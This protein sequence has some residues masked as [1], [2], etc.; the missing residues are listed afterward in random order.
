MKP[1]TKSLTGRASKLKTTKKA[2][3]F[4]LIELITVIVIVGVLATAISTFIKFGTQAY[5]QT[6]D[7]DQLVL[8]A[9]FAIERLNS[10]V[11]NALPNSLRL[12]NT[13]Q[14]VEF[15]P[16]L[17]STIYT[18]I[19][20]AP[21]SAS[22]TISVI[23]FSQ[24]F[25]NN[26]QAIVYPL[27]PDDVY[28]NTSSNVKK[29]AIDSINITGEEWLITLENKVLFAQDSPTQRIYFINGSVKYCLQN[30]TLLRSDSLT[31]DV[32]LMAQDIFNPTGKAP[33]EVLAATL[34][35]NAMVQI[36]LQ[37][38]KNNE[39]VSFNN[40]IQVLNVP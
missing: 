4:T 36:H 24:A 6:T 39:K 3:G 11:R 16:I 21:E 35:R 18:D 27:T 28:G 7:R 9:R 25:D 2:S 30:N 1:L 13:G 20:V 19:P 5:T 17:D 38:E 12:T 33:F 23:P 34:Q 10:E 40:E 14:C 8:S 15:T 22:A 37:F 32:L 26:W 31:A 29:H